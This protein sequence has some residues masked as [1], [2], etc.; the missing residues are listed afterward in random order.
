MNVSSAPCLHGMAA[1]SY[2]IRSPCSLSVPRFLHTT[3]A[4]HAKKGKKHKPK[5]NVDMSADDSILDLEELKRDMQKVIEALKQDYTKSLSIRTSQGSL[6]HIMVPTSDGKFPLNQ[7]GQIT[8]K[9]ASLITV[10]LNVSGFPQATEAA[11]K[12]IRE[13]GMNLNPKVEGGII[14]VPIPK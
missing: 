7:L 4:Y 5:V 11:A 2:S 10:N 13:S 1:N 3:C 12:A 8:S 6:D 9:S 14:Q